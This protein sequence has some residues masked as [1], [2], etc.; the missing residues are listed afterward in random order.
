MLRC[1][2]NAK[3]FKPSKPK[4]GVRG[5]EKWRET[6]VGIKI[7]RIR[8]WI[9]EVD[10]NVRGQDNEFCALLGLSAAWVVCPETSVRYYHSTLPR[11]IPEAGRAHLRRGGSLRPRGKNNVWS[12][13]V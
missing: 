13:S 2:E 12:C 5:R 3:L 8:Q 1:Q 4:N 9:V 10:R 6:F 11:I 7:G